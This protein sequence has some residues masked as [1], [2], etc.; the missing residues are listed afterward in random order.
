M[1]YTQDLKT[2]EI[3]YLE[4]FTAPKVFTGLIFACLVTDQVRPA[5]TTV[6]HRT[7]THIKDWTHEIYK[8]ERFSQLINKT[9]RQEISHLITPSKPN[10]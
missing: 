7:N 2:G 5:H 4:N 8:P 6:R 1:E 9:K 10:Q 3:Y